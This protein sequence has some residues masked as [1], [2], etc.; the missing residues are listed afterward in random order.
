MLR[1]I[2]MAMAALVVGVAA[3]GSAHADG[4]PKIYA[5]P[6]SD[7]FANFQ[8]KVGATGVLWSNKNDGIYQ[9][10]TLL[11]GWD[12][13]VGDVWLP[14]ATLTYFFNPKLSAELFCC[15][16]TAKVTG[17]G[18]IDGVDLA[19]TWAFPPIVTLKYHFDKIGSVR[20]YVGAGVQYIHYFSSK[21]V[22]AG[23]DGVSLKDSWGPVAQAGFDLELGRGWSVGFDAKYVWEKTDLTFTDST[24]TNANATTK[25]TLDPLLL[26]VNVGYRFNLEDLLGRRSATYE[27][28][29]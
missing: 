11:G 19:K 6:V 3:A 23:Y 7:P 5:G 16:A 29:K 9:G 22:L 20:P 25:H 4:M 24:G 2:K 28:L 21:S 12:A 8:V 13:G 17:K 15:F 27:P 1:N 26:T 14:T 18:A 10:G